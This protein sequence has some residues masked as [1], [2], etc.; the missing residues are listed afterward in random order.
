M[1]GV[2][3]EGRLDVGRLH[4]RIADEHHRQR[5]VELIVDERALLDRVDAVERGLHVD[6]P[7]HPGEARLGD[8][9]LVQVAPR[10]DPVDVADDGVDEVRLEPR[11]A[12]RRVGEVV[13]VDV[14]VDELE[15]SSAI[16]QRSG[17]G[18]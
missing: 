3:G 6:D 16:A 14:G 2:A 5:P 13:E 1:L 7:D 10:L 4:P 18:A 17:V 8:E 12:Q 9:V 15:A 11:V